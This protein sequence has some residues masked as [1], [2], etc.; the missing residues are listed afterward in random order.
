VDHN[1]TREFLIGRRRDIAAERAALK[2]R[3]EELAA[4]EADIRNVCIQLKITLPTDTGSEGASKVG[5]DDKSKDAIV[6][7]G[8]KV[9]LTDAILLVLQD[10]GPEGASRKQMLRE[11]K[12]RFH[13]DVKS[14][15]L[16]GP[17][18]R[19]MRSGLV[20]HDTEK[21]VYRVITKD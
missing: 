17:L 12:E 9:T 16:S 4:E 6:I 21:K 1:L 3:D 13:F 2:K 20:E 7:E 14:N 10:A 11:L 5:S 19:Y 18:S 15:S 8:T